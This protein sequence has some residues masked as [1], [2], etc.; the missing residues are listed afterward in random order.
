MDERRKIRVKPRMSAPKMGEYLE[1][2]ANRRAQILREQ[3]FPPLYKMIRYERARAAVRSALLAGGD[4]DSSLRAAADRIAAL[5]ARND[6]ERQT[7]SCS[8][9]AIRRFA[10]LLPALPMKGVAVLAPA[11][12]TLLL[13]VEGVAIS[14]S[15]TV[16]LRRNGRNDD[17]QYGALVVVINKS[18]KLAESG[19][20]A[21]AELVRQSL[22]ANGYG[23]VRP[24]LCVAVDVFGNRVY[25]ASGRGQRIS[26]ELASACR[27]IAILWPSVDH[28]RAA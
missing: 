10:T 13:N 24:D 15:V 8:A 3:K 21:V 7:N 28:K 12:A 9:Q 22:A 6:Y 23:S 2:L 19:G 5:P 14:V 1:V 26:R 11:A 18:V 27:E 25:T 4:V 20:K 17:A 16:L